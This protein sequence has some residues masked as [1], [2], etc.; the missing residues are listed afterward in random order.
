MPQDAICLTAIVSRS[1]SSSHVR[2]SSSRSITSGLSA[3]NSSARR[4]PARSSFSVGTRELSRASTSSTGLPR[5]GSIDQAR[6]SRLVDLSVVVPVYRCDECL[7]ALRDRITAA[8]TPLAIEWELVLIDDG[9]PDRAWL[10]IRTLAE[11]DKRVRGL[12][13]ARN[14]GQHAAITAGLAEATGR[15]IVVMD[16]DLQDPP[17]DIPRLLERADNGYEIVLARRVERRHSHF[18]RL[19]AS[20]YFS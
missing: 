7:R 20:M 14:F 5:S 18:R 6:G 8:L 15:R 16:C 4:D 12:R 10:T 9:S 19:A 13:L 3:M 1:T 2:T 11:E 17:E